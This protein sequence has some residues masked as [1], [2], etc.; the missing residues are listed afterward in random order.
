MQ[1]LWNDDFHHS[2]VVALTGRNEA[3]YTDYH[4]TPQELISAV[5]YGY[6]YQGQRYKWQ[7]QRRGTPALDLRPTQFVN[8]IEN[9][10]Q[11]ANSGR[12]ERL[13]RLTSP[14]RYKALTALLLLS[15]G[16]PMLFQGQEFAASTPFYYFADHK[17][18]LA[19]MI[20]EGRVKFLSQFPSLATAEMQACLIDPGNP[21]SFQ[22][23][24]LD[25]HDRERNTAYYAL[26][27]DLIRLR[28]EDPVFRR[29]G[30]VDGAVLSTEALLLR[31][32]GESGDA[33]LLLV[34][35]GRDLHLDPAPEPLLAPPEGLSW[36]LLWS[37]ED[38]RYGGRGTPPPESDENWRIPGH[39]AIVM[40]P[41]LSQAIPDE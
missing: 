2:A 24:K 40:R 3:Y 1:A 35:L 20:R 39:A 25:F 26:H 27:K 7:K 36:E 29:Q 11:V 41:Q 17:P 32:F 6:L 28:R 21:S 23:S 37:S 33:R 22:K 38:T 5:K 16:T 4:G 13:H 9:H 34:N 19:K 14:G 31:F 15:P 10:D 30:A 8:F 12:G 18:E